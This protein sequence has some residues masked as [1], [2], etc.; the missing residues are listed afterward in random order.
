MSRVAFLTDLGKTEED[1]EDPK[2][3]GRWVNNFQSPTLR[4]GGWS[5]EL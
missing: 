5:Y 1:V 4:Q 2:Q 3:I